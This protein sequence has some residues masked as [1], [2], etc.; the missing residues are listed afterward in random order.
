MKMKNATTNLSKRKCLTASHWKNRLGPLGLTAFF[1]CSFAT[2]A[3]AQWTLLPT[4]PS[5]VNLA[6]IQVGSQAW[7]RDG[8][9]K[10]YGDI[11]GTF[12][13]VPLPSGETFDSIGA[14]GEGIWSREFDNGPCFQVPSVH[15]QLGAT[16]D[17]RANGA[18]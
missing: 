1:L 18:F 8:S 15:E 3:S 6:G 5:G 10:V 2:S 13:N 14:S 16:G 12:V 17:R 9:G 11:G 7:G 4:S